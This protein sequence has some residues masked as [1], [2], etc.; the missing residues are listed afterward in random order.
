MI[1]FAEGA[2]MQGVL[3]WMLVAETCKF[4]FFGGAFIMKRVWP[5]A[6]ITILAVALCASSGWGWS[7]KLGWTYDAKYPISSSVAVA[8]GLVIAGDNSGSLHAVYAASGQAAWVYEGSNKVVGLPTVSGE[9]VVFAQADGTITALSLSNGSEVWKYAPPEAGYAAETVVDGVAI[10]DGKVMFVK[11]DGKLYALSASNGRELWTYDSGMELRNAPYF[12]NGVVFI[13]EQRGLFTA[14]NPKT[15]K[16]EWGGGAGGAINTPTAEGG[17]VYFSSW[18][19]SV[20]SVQI[21]GVVPQWKADAGEPVTTP[22]FVEGGRVFVGTAGGKVVAFSKADGA[23]LWSFDTQGGAVPG[24]PV[25]AEGLVFACGG[26]G[27]L[28]VLDAA[29]GAERFTF[30]TGVDINGAP[31]YSGG[32][33]FMGSGDGRIYAIREAGGAI[34]REPQVLPRRRYRPLSRQ[35]GRK[36][37]AIKMAFDFKKEFRSE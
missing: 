20:Q 23:A 21:K 3:I 37:E 29:S 8:G 35:R 32:I 7:G 11:G 26:Q 36:T 28:F 22:P 10:G 9:M 16:R 19:G 24:T 17:N 34:P 15:G 14:L 31:A 1:T 27:T 13:G 6:L 12:Y 4:L 2:V 25:S 33:L 5:G 18:D 30:Q